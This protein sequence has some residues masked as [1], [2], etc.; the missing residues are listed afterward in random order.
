VAS[1]RTGSRHNRGCAIDLTIIDNK[2][3]RELEMPTPFDDFT[4]KASH[5]FRNVPEKVLEN[6][7]LLHDI[8]LKH[9][10]EELESEWWHYDFVGWRNFKIMDISFDELT[11]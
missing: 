3:G 5:T 8:M 9:G 6:R 11:K 10:F 4:A 2:S 7:K 1:P